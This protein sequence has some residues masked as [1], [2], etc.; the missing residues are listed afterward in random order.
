[1]GPPV[2]K[3]CTSISSEHWPRM[4]APSG[5][6]K[7]C[8]RPKSDLHS[9]P[10]ITVVCN[11]MYTALATGN[12]TLALPMPIAPCLFL[13]TSC[14]QRHGVGGSTDGFGMSRNWKCQRQLPT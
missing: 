8:E 3:Q 9:E 1:N 12:W 6:R 10:P 4:R 11:W 5:T 7:F 13:T 2:D 14:V